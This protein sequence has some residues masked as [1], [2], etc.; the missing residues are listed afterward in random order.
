MPW[1]DT[2]LMS[3]DYYI[4]L[5]I[6]TAS[7]NTLEAG[8]KTSISLCHTISA[9]EVGQVL[10]PCISTYKVNLEMNASQTASNWCTRSMKTWGSSTST[11]S[12]APV[13]KRGFPI[14]L[15][16]LPLKVAS[17][18]STLLEKIKDPSPCLDLLL[19]S[20]FYWPSFSIDS[21]SPET[22]IKTKHVHSRPE[23]Y[24]TA[25]SAAVCLLIIGVL[26]YS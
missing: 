21:K 6:R 10:K 26:R 2:V 5:V 13:D 1:L 14:L 11:S 12:S 24:Q 8:K 3:T 9:E 16:R 15:K 20:F 4:D 25:L 19:F 22:M 17:P 7:L 23:K 18:F